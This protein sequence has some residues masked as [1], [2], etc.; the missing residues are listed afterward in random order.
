MMLGDECSECR[1]LLRQAGQAILEHLR[2]VSGLEEAVIRAEGEDVT[3]LKEK[4]LDTG[5]ARENSVRAYNEHKAG[6]A[7]RAK[8]AST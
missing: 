3:T 8:T 4:V 7:A 5:I 6:H 2:A 1:N